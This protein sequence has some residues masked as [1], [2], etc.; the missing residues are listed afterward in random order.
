M[1]NSRVIT[2]G[3][4]ANEF[5]SDMVIRVRRGLKHQCRKSC[6]CE[7]ERWQENEFSIE[8]IQ[9]NSVGM[10]CDEVEPRISLVKGS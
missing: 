5:R 6:S 10:G 1:P 7:V 9:E 3:P 8:L 2:A 4:G